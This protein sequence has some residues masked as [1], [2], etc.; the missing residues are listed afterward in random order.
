[1]HPLQA[2]RVQ[3]P[4]GVGGHVAHAVGRTHRQVDPVAQRR[5]PQVGHAQVV[6]ALAQADIAVVQPQDP[7]ATRHQQLHQ[8]VGPA[9]ELHA[10]AHDQQQRLGVGGALVVKLDLD[11]VRSD[12][13]LE[14]RAGLQW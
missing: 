11:A 9:N 4:Q 5:Q 8:L 13:H 2:Q 12:L 7:K 14:G 1:M 3:H 10:Q 6:E